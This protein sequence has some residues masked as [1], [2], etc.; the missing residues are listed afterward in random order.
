MNNEKNTAFLDIKDYKKL[1]KIQKR[2][3]FYVP[4]RKRLQNVIL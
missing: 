1:K 2:T 3:V 4:K